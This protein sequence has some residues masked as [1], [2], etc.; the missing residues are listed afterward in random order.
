VAYGSGED[1]NEAA[2]AAVQAGPVVTS[3]A[4][5]IG[6]RCRHEQSEPSWAVAT[7]SGRSA[8]TWHRSSSG[9]E[10]RPEGR[11]SGNGRAGRAP[12]PA[13]ALIF[14]T[15]LSGPVLA[16]LPFLS[17]A[18]RGRRPGQAAP[19]GS[20]LPNAWSAGGWT[21]GRWK[22]AGL[23]TARGPHLAP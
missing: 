5:R 6:R 12:R 2:A 14:R 10:R 15:G 19:W 4:G 1:V 17:G 20:T 16:A 18:P 23:G 8:C 13:A 22:P 7:A 9:C 3:L 11:R 21:V